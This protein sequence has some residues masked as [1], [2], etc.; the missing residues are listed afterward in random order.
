MHSASA[1]SHVLLLAYVCR[2]HGICPA[3][4]CKWKAQYGGLQV[5]EAPRL[6]VLA[7]EN[8]A[9]EV[10]GR[11]DAGQRDAEGRG[12]KKV[13]TP[14]TRR[15]AV[16]H[17]R[18]EHAVSERRAC[19]ALGA[20]HS[21]VRYRARRGDD[22]VVRGRL[23][24]LASERRRFGYRRL[25]L[26]LSREGVVLNHKKLRRLYGQ[27][28]VQVRRRGG[29]KRALAACAPLVQAAAPNRRS[30]LDFVSDAVLACIK[31]A[32]RRLRRCP[33]ARLDPGCARRP[34]SL[35]PGRRSGARPN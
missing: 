22:A 35:R 18:V 11:C 15:E 30:S 10:A 2:R 1:R 28:K 27:E 13:V 34:G 26:L 33:S 3:T 4:F 9:Q 19:Q 14:D 17:L 7:V 31:A 20:D 8:A 32:A 16:A 23:R 21:V 6:R 5:F 25:G 29:R 24:A 12:L